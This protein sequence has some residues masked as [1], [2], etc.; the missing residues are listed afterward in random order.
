MVEPVGVGGVGRAAESK[1]PFE[2]VC[3]EGCSSVVS[4]GDCGEFLGFA[5]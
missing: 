5:D 4:G 1:V 2:Q 3:F